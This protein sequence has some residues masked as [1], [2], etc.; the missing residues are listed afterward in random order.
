MINRRNFLRNAS[1]FTVGS[2]VAGK[3]GTAHAAQPASSVASEAAAGKS[4][5][6]QI[7]SLGKELYTDVPGG[8][9][10]LK[11]MGYTTLELAGYG[12][13]KINGVEL[14]EFKK[15]AD[16]AGLKI[17]SSH[18]N[19]PVSEYT[20]DN[21]GSI[22]EFWKKVADDHAKLGVKYLVQPGQPSTR[23]V[24]ETKFVCEVFNEAGKISKAAGFP[25]GYHNHDF[26]FAKVVSGGSEA[27]FGRHNKGE[28]IYDIFLNNTDP[29]LVLF[30]LDVYWAV[31]GQV[32][33][34]EYMQKY[35]DR[36]KLL[37]IKDRSILG[38]SGM[39]NFETIFKQFY[40]NGYKDYFVEIESMPNGGT[41]FEGVKGCADYLTKASFVKK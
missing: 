24:E 31:M 4:I 38:Q 22:K 14:L 12:D 41:Q 9:K 6:L 16:D 29:S 33:P 21:L 7:Y 18:V 2:L 1:L 34:V 13:G 10:N 8:M 19:P 23:N 27:K 39:M 36:I 11:Q 20:K 37:H 40:K 25:F 5:G 26:E 35:P 17:I 3:M 15:M 30:E 28:V 32:D